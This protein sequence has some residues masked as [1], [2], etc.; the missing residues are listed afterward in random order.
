MRNVDHRGLHTTI[1][2]LNVTAVEIG[3]FLQNGGSR[4]AEGWG[5]WKDGAEGK[6]G[7]RYKAAGH[8]LKAASAPD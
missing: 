3:R 2:E 5:S 4:D 7:G 6:R 1:T 8:R